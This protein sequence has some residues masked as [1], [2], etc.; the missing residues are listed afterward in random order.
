MAYDFEFNVEPPFAPGEFDAWQATIPE[1][2]QLLGEASADGKSLRFNGSYTGSGVNI[3]V[4]FP[5]LFD[6][7]RST[8]RRLVFA[9]GDYDPTAYYDPQR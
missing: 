1:D 6:W 2:E 5:L 8:G 9:W 3:P 4:Y 7:A